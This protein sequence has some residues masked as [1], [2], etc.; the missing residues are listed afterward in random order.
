LRSGKTPL[1]GREQELDLLL[2]L[3]TKTG[4]G[5]AVLLSGEPGIG[6]SRL[7]SA[8]QERILGEPHTRIRYF[9]SP[10][11]QH[12]ALYP[13]VGQLERAAGFARDDGPRAGD[14]D[15][16]DAKTASGSTFGRAV[17]LEVTPEQAEKV[18]VAAELGKLSLTLRSVSEAVELRCW[19]VLDDRLADRAASQWGTAVGEF[20]GQHDVDTIPGI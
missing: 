6:K 3:W 14:R 19:R 10:H 15:A 17:T 1:V 9:C 13:I 16:L 18:N 8:V 11:H 20:L 5:R 2:R 7:T 12:S 4:E